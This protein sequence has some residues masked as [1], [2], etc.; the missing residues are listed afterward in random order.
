MDSMASQFFKIFWQWEYVGEIN[1]FG[2]AF[3]VPILGEIETWA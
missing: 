2:G 1:N 3:S